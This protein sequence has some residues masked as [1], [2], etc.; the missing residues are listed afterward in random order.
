MKRFDF[1]AD[2][3]PHRFLIEGWAT[4]EA[5]F[6][7][8]QGRRSRVRVVPP[9]GAG[10]LTLEISLTPFRTPPTLMRQRLIVAVNGHALLVEEVGH[11]CTLG[12]ELPEALAEAPALHITLHCPD[13]A[14]PAARGA[15]GD[16]R[17]LGVA[18]AEMVLRRAP[19]GLK[20][21][22]RVMPPLLDGGRNLPDAVQALCGMSI[23]EL[24]TQF[25]SLGHDCSFGHAQR[26]MGVETLSLLRYAGLS[27]H[28]LRQ[29]LADG[30]AKL[31]A[32]GNLRV[33]SNDDG[34]AREFMV[35]DAA[36]E[37]TLHS[38]MHAHQIDADAVLRR[39]ERMLRFLRRKFCEDLAEGRKIW[40]F[41]HPAIPSL[42]AAVPLL[43]MLREYGPNKLLFVSGDGAQPAGTV[44]QAGPD[45]FHGWVGRA[46][47]YGAAPRLDLAGWLSVCA[48]AYHLDRTA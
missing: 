38:A 9:A 33:Y 5:G 20:F 44:H 37:M 15:G 46:A 28:H 16:M 34:Y 24:G 1:G 12:W 10:V 17:I 43:N 26:Q 39:F 2:A 7:W 21:A 35:H 47:A 42:A 13:A 22:K 23:A 48:N 11:E 19:P 27:P 4:P 30:F 32:P 45:L 3:A 29:G 18:V 6:T 8:T 40:V 25:E 14:S 36:Y 31:A 41:Q